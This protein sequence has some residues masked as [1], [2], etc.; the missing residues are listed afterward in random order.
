MP[1]AAFVVPVAP[2]TCPLRDVEAPAP[3]VGTGDDD[4]DVDVVVG[5]GIETMPFEIVA[6]DVQLEEAGMVPA[7]GVAGWPCWKVDVP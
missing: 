3:L 4:D 6:K 1:T 7:A 2:A 5:L